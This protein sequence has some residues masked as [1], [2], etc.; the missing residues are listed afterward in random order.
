MAAIV[1]PISCARDILG[2]LVLIGSQILVFSVQTIAINR[3]TSPSRLISIV[4]T[5]APSER[6]LL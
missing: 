3:N 4:S 6:E 5:P 1:I 2:N